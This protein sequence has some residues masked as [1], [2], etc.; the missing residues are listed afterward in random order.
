MNILFLIGNGFDINLGMK[1]RYQD[2]YKFYSS[3]KSS[4][5]LVQSLKDN[6]AN[7][8]ENWSDLEIALG[9]YTEHLKTSDEFIE[10]YEDLEDKLAEY[11]K[12]VKDKFEFNKIEGKKLYNFLVHPENSLPTADKN[13][14]TAFRQKWSNTQWNIFLFTFNYTRSLEKLLN[15]NGKEIVLTPYNLDNI[16][17][18]I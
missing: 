8:I 12:D 11:L 10:V 18:R 3:I 2:F 4:N 5:K 17:K 7:N 16:I 15:Y 9:K 1:T 14:V 6:I 13:L